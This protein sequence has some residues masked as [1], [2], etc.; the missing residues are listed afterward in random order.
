MIVRVEV[1]PTENLEKVRKALEN[2]FDAEVL[3]TEKIE[4][5]TL[6]IAEGYSYR[7]LSKLYKM[8]RS[9]YILDAAREHLKRGVYDYGVIFYLNKQAAYAGVVSF[10]NQEYGESPLGAI[11]FDVQVSDPQRLIDWL[12]PRTLNGKPI[13]EIEPPLED[14]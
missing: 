10:C 6:L 5:Y 9:Q 1:R 12:T 13:K 11:V 7:C 3:K 4:D 8:I 14:P 2:V